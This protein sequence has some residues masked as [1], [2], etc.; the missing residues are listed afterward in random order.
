MRLFI[1]L[2]WESLDSSSSLRRM[3]L[4]AVICLASVSG[5]CWATLPDDFNGLVAYRWNLILSGFS[6]VEWLSFVWMLM[7][8]ASIEID[9]T[10]WSLLV[11]WSTSGGFRRVW[12]GILMTSF[13]SLLSVRFLFSSS[14][15]S[16]SF[17]RG[18][19]YFFFNGLGVI[20]FFVRIWQ[21][22]QSAISSSVAL[23][24]CVRH[25]FKA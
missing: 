15:R 25:F 1:S 7:V 13:C 19:L 22:K 24:P 8:S 18:A 3:I 9:Y 14:T 21:V 5:D 16:F 23:V 6:W 4:S 12:I 2:E 17:S 11:V 20:S 10:I